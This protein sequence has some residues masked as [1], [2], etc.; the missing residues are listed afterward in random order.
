MEYQD[1]CS[2]SQ[3]GSNEKNEDVI[4]MLRENDVLLDLVCDGMSGYG[5]GA[6]A[7]TIAAEEIKY[8]VRTLSES[9]ISLPELITAAI[10]AADER[11]WKERLALKSKFGT[12]LGG[13]IAKGNLFYAFWIGDVKIFQVRQGNIIFES[14]EH[15]LH[16]VFKYSIEQKELFSNIVTASLCGRGTGKLTTV[17][18]EVCN[19]D[20]IIICSDGIWKKDLIGKIIVLDNESLNTLCSENPFEDDH[21]LVKFRIGNGN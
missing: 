12:T 17:Q 4:V 5:Y 20:W 16:N 14:R 21:T 7:A 13:V 2:Y 11:L 15:S 9:D 18:L 10:T 3:K 19:E 8:A 6:L 1:Y